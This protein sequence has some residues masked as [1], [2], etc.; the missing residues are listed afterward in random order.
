MWDN[1]P[2]SGEMNSHGKTK[3][4]GKKRFPRLAMKTYLKF[5]REMFSFETGRGLVLI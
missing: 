2:I 5:F 3:I 4:S 1:Q